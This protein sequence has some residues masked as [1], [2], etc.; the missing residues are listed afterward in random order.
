MAFH[1]L[2]STPLPT[3]IFS[4]I[5]EAASDSGATLLVFAP[6]FLGLLAPVVLGLLP[7]LASPGPDS[8]SDSAMSLTSSTSSLLIARSRAGGPADAGQ[9]S[10]E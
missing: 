10:V 5:P 3:P 9:P 2:S 6:V 8:K 1:L 7:V 4:D